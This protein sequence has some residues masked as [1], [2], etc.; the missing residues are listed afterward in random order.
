M[1]LLD[2]ENFVD[3]IKYPH[4]KSI[5]VNTHKKTYLYIIKATYSKPNA[6]PN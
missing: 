6:T 4:D 2:A 5:R 1:I 3:K